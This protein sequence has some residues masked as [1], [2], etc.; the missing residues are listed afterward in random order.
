MAIPFLFRSE[1]RYIFMWW[2][3]VLWHRK[4]VRTKQSP[5]ETSFGKFGHFLFYTWNPNGAPCFDWNFGLLLEGSTPKTKDK[6]GSRY[7]W[8]KEYKIDLYDL[9]VTYV[10]DITCTTFI[11]CTWN[12][13]ITFKMVV[14]IGWFQ[15]FTNETSGW[16]FQP[17]WKILVKN[18]NLPQIGMKIKSVWNHHLVVVCSSRCN[19][20]NFIAAMTWDALASQDVGEMLARFRRWDQ[21]VQFRKLNMQR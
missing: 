12:L 13:N 16:W 10:A 11:A 14:L 8:N 17:I 3:Q 19:F 1:S 21:I 6:T 5:F 15:S 4:S 2:C 18:W 7:S 20:S 9:F